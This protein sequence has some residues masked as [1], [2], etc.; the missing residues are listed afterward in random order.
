M[1]RIADTGAPAL[2]SKAP[3][4]I[5]GLDAVTGGGPPRGRPTL[6]C[7]S[8]GCGK[9][10]L[11]MEFLVHGA[12]C[13]DEPGV[14]LSFDETDDDLTVNFAS[15]GID[16]RDLQDR[17]KI[18]IDHVEI[19]RSQIQESGEYDLEGLFVRLGSAADSI[20]AKRVALDSLESLFAGLS[21]EAILRSE[22]IRLFRWLKARGLSAVVT[23]E[24]GVRGFTR[25]GLEEYI[26]DCVIALDHRIERQVSTRRLRVVKYRGTTHGADEYPF[27]IHGHGL[28]VLPVTEVALSHPASTER[29][30]SGIPGLD[31][32]LEGRG[33]HRGGSVLVSGTAGTGKSSVAAHFVEAACR[34]GE[35]C[36][37]LA[38]EESPDQ[39]VRNMRSIGMDLGRWIEGGRLRFLAARP[40]QFGLDMHLAALQSH[41]EEFRPTIAVI[42]PI[43]S[44]TAVGSATEIQSMLMR[45][46]D[47]LKGRQITALFSSLTHPDA[48]RLE[49]IDAGVSSL[50]DTWLLL[51][52]LETPLERRR[53]IRILKS[54]GMAHT[55]QTFDFRFTNDGIQVE[56]PRRG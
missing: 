24:P 12:L 32:M 47:F 18:V 42:D 50:M 34:R 43:T 36:L 54:R 38:F 55:N 46:V 37:Y 10:M 6:V 9:T 7:G 30:S 29:V 44:F 31:A 17:K 39:I 27:I 28:D 40:T 25:H 13:C 20:G 33:Y 15:L 56:E 52:D 14:F 48:N 22:L 51:F 45:A 41:I 53:A 16:L 11:A 5:F 2:L 4:G 8:A 49:W 3:T 26:S 35:R 19:E 23:G 21:N 1:T